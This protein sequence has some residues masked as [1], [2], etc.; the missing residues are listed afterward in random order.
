MHSKPDTRHYYINRG[1]NS[2]PPLSHV[3]LKNTCRPMT[4]QRLVSNVC[5]RWLVIGRQVFFRITW[6]NGGQEF[7]VVNIVIKCGRLRLAAAWALAGWAS[8]PTG[9][10]RDCHSARIGLC[11]DLTV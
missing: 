5:E 4:N 1:S 9:G 6:L 11:W 3:I 8:T 10:M 7:P 2:C